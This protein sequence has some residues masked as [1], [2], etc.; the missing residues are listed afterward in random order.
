MIDKAASVAPRV[1][2]DWP[3]GDA[4]ALLYV[5]AQ[6]DGRPHIDATAALWGASIAL[7][8]RDGRTPNG[9]P[10]PPTNGEEVSS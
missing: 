2:P 6:L 3:E 10:A 5:M 4:A 9:Y 8:V 1:H 7:I